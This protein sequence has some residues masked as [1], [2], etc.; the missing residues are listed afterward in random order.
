VL[1]DLPLTPAATLAA[2]APARRLRGQATRSDREELVRV[3][4][5]E[6]DPAMRDL[7]IKV[8][9]HLGLNVVGRGEPPAG[10]GRS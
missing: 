3:L 5:V 2:S 9:E 6:D 1:K 8:F 4:V 7:L 10:A